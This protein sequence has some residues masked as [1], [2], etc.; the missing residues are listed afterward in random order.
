MTSKKFM[1]LVLV[2]L[3]LMAVWWTNLWWHR[4]AP[5]PV[6]KASP[7]QAQPAV[8]PPDLRALAMQMGSGGTAAP[9]P[10][11]IKEEQQTV[12]SQV[13]A[14]GE[15]LNNADP[16]E[17]IGGALQLAAY[18]TK[19]AESMLLKAIIEDLEPDVR[20][21]AI[22]SLQA[23]KSLGEPSIKALLNALG[24]D[25]EEVRGA[26]LNTLSSLLSRQD[27]DS[28]PYKMMMSKLKQKTRDH[29]LPAGTR[30]EIHDF[31]EDQGGS[32]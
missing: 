16:Q 15:S 11:Q 24:D 23:F 7:Q 27:H 30:Q 4:I 18:P 12:G 13:A 32:P 8:P 19:E 28:K 1:R 9:T 22:D 21:T 10:E 2:L 25:T 26:A 29:R 6:V 31:L 3:A 20:K 17:R 5:P 14:A